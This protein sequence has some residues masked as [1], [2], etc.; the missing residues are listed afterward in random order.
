MKIGA[1][2]SGNSARIQLGTAALA[3]GR[4]AGSGC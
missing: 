1:A 4:P 3:F 2:G